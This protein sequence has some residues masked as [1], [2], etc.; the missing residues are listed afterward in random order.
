M[1]RYKKFII[2]IQIIFSALASCMS[3]KKSE[4]RYDFKLPE[5]FTIEVAAGPDLVDFPM[6][7][8]VDETGR[9]FVF[10]S[11]GDVYDSTEEALQNPQFRIKLLVDT[12][13]DGKYDKSTVFADKIGFPQG[14]VFY[15]GSL[16]ASSAP[17][18][19]KLTDR[20]GD[21]I[22]E[23]RDVLLSGWTL[24]VNANSLIGPFMAPDGWFYMTSA[25][26][27][28]DVK[29]KEGERMKGETARIWRMKPDGSE[30]QW[31]SAG[32]MNNPVGLAFTAASE[33]L[34]TMTYFT[35]PSAGQRDALIYWTEG[36]VYPK[37]NSNIQR[38]NLPLTGELMPVVSKYSRVAPAGVSRYQNVTLGEAYHNTLF[39]A[40]FNTHRIINHKLTRNGG[41]FR[42]E[43]TVFL[44]TENEDFHPTDVLEDGDGSLLIIETGGWFLKGCPLSQVSKPEVKGTV[45]RVR[46]KN[47]SKVDD[48]FGN[49]INWDKTGITSMV[50]YLE[51]SRP[52]VRNRAA[53]MI[54]DNTGAIEPLKDLLANSQ[55]V[56]SRMLAT[57]VLYKMNNPEA[58]QNAQRSL[59]DKNMEVRIAASR[60]AGL[61]NDT[62]AIEGLVNM[63]HS[64]DL[65]VKR[66]AA[67]AL[68]Q[69][70]DPKT[71]PHLLEAA[72]GVSDRF[73]DHAITYAL[74]SM[75]K[76]EL[77]MAGLKHT[78]NKVK[79]VALI[80]LDQMKASP[81]HAGMVVSYLSSEDSLLQATS[82]WVTT[83]HPE[84]AGA[85]ARTLET[86]L[87][88]PELSEKEKSQL[89]QVL[90]PF[91]SSPLIQN[92]VASKMSKASSDKKRFLME[93]M[94]KCE[95]PEFP[96]A[97][98][99]R[100]Q[101]ELLTS[102][103]PE[104]KFDAL[105]LVR[106]RNLTKL[107]EPV[108]RV[109][110]DGNNP[111]N[112]RLFA[113]G[114]LINDSIAMTAEQFR[115]LYDQLREG[116]DQTLRQQAATYLANARLQNEQILKL[117]TEIIPSADPF[118]LQKLAP[119][120]SRT[121][122]R[123]AGQSLIDALMKSPA[124]DN[125]TES[126]I[127]EIFNSYSPEIK[128]SVSKLITKL[129]A[130]HAERL[131]RIEQVEKQIVNGDLD[132][133][134]ALFFGKAIC[135]QCHTLG[136]EGGFLGPDLTSI[137]KDRSVHDLVEAVLYPGVSFVREYET[138]Q[139][140]T[141]SHVY[142][143]IIKEQNGSMVRI[144]ISP[145]ESVRIP[146][147]EIVSIEIKNK[148]MMPEGLDALLTDQEFSDLMAF[149]LAQDQDPETDSKLLR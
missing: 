107:N 139:V 8:T 124:L 135:S 125:F 123:L 77:T 87:N 144:D 80:A 79:R 37:P 92:L 31:V 106:F 39:S 81:L 121:N 82:L 66:Q 18:I 55:S 11:I 104:I 50:G 21:G 130:L 3:D 41:S 28:F 133:G 149:I 45:Y 62:S 72:E 35:E 19:L 108:F 24:N 71:I 75:N 53:S 42:A 14:G 131:A 113:Y 56:E 105:G 69:I 33:P 140:K 141:K 100:I 129:K 47:A 76:P 96:V 116:N 13:G 10:E 148:S 91:C 110:S 120:F 30:L 127:N 146:A 86:R 7:A 99:D 25:I 60:A 63:L 46:R 57:F 6:F 26:E 17:D 119:L 136:K 102:N 48:P 44:S 49:Q 111:A 51:D 74:L 67:T 137:Q 138:Y 143:G 36:G 9:L 32:G 16:Y 97:W 109:A 98:S 59:T 12:N 93:V 132:N 78:S 65:A 20:D 2:G 94:E 145:Q 38:D 5:G 64:D 73:V 103:D 122:D 95:T 15:E 4:V 43:E 90:V 85:I 112:L 52:F 118:I 54:K 1:N 29:S 70:G 126:S 61:A 147:K 101:I 22:A 89:R 84:W 83:H 114:L 68:G 40:Q 34:G 134:R 128:I 115:Y 23:Q 27:G 142:T 88:K 117:S 58:Y